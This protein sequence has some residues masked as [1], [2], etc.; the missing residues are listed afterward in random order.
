MSE[1]DFIKQYGIPDKIT[2]GTCKAR[3]LIDTS[4]VLKDYKRRFLSSL[5]EEVKKERAFAASNYNSPREKAM[6][7]IERLIENRLD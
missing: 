5:L 3:F 2:A 1:K 6:T 4:K 7:D